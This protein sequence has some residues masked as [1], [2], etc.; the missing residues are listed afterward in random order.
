MCQVYSCDVEGGKLSY[1]VQLWRQSSN[2]QLPEGLMS[3]AHPPAILIEPAATQIG[4]PFLRLFGDSDYFK[5]WHYSQ[6]IGYV[7]HYP[8]VIWEYIYLA[9]YRFG[10]IEILLGLSQE[11][12]CL[13]FFTVLGQTGYILGIFHI[14]L[15]PDIFHRYWLY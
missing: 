12:L 14:N 8:C 9:T 2:L 13:A 10:H 11:F 7:D 3:C 15:I 4:S 6:G 5:W 1:C